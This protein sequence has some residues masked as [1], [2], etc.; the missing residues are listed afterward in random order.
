MKR[1]AVLAAAVLIG[2]MALAQ[3]MG[4]AEAGTAAPTMS[5]TAEVSTA[6][7]LSAFIQT[8]LS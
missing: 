7:F 2:G 1:I 5:P 4:C 8:V 3:P 6:N